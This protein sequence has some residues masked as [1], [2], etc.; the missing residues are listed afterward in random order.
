MEELDQ[1]KRRR[2]ISRIPRAIGKREQAK[3]AYQEAQTAM[4]DLMDESKNK[5][6]RIRLVLK[7]FRRTIVLLCRR[8]E[9]LTSRTVRQGQIGEFLKDYQTAL[10]VLG[11]AANRSL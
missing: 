6:A 7:L 8:Q 9:C 3:V 10:E 11:L 2:P 4:F 1:Y 5:R